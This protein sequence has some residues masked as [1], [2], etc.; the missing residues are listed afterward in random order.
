MRARYLYSRAAVGLKRLYGGSRRLCRTG[1]GK[2]KFVPKGEPL[3]DEA[4]EQITYWI[5]NFFEEKRK[6]RRQSISRLP[7]LLAQ[8]V[9]RPGGERSA[10][11]VL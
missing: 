9:D 6:K 10:G 8:L 5:I 4:A 7:A 2:Y 1:K 11:L 3:V